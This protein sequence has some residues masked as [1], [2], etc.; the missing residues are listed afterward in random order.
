MKSFKGVVIWDLRIFERAVMFQLKNSNYK[1]DALLHFQ[2]NGNFGQN[3]KYFWNFQFFQERYKTLFKKFK[4]H[5]SSL[6]LRWKEREKFWFK[7]GKFV[8]FHNWTWNQQF[9]W[10]IEFLELQSV[11]C[12][13]IIH[14]V[15]QENKW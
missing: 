12:I 13:E 15:N 6:S 11:L 2:Q 9:I 14:F 8:K 10:G 1:L 7:E 3:F 4:A 5:S